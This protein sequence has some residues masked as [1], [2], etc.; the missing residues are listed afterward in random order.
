MKIFKKDYLQIQY[1]ERRDPA[2]EARR[3]ATIS[4]SE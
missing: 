1:P 3:Q 2:P 4:R